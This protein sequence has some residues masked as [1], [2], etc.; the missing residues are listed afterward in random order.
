MLL[1]THC[2]AQM[3]FI[4]WSCLSGERCGPWTSC[5]LLQ[6]L[7]FILFHVIYTVCFFSAL[8]VYLLRL[9]LLEFRKLL[10][11]VLALIK[12]KKDSENYLC[13]YFEYITFSSTNYL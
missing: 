8:A 11:E 3:F 7:Y 5:S 12:Y 10:S 2:F 1:Y 13:I 6:V 4:D 9:K